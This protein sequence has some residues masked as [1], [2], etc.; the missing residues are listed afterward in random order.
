MPI[1]V[2][3]EGSSVCVCTREKGRE[4]A[5]ERERKALEESENRTL[6][7]W[8]KHAMTWVSDMSI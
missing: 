6:N 1:F 2:A 7:I 3:Q 5:R 8:Y 4:W